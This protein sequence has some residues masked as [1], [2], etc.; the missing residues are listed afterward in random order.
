MILPQGRWRGRWQVL[1]LAFL[2]GA[3]AALALA[4]FNLWFVIFP[5]FAVVATLIVT[6]PSPR[7]AAWRAWSAGAGWFALSVHWIVQPF[8][9]DPLATGW[10]APF[11]LV[12]LA[13]G[14]ALFWGLAGW[15]SARIC[16]GPVRALA[17]AGL[18]TL[19]EALRGRV[20]TGLPWAEPGHGLIG[21]EALA[22]S[23]FIGPYGLTLVVLILSAGTAALFMAD[24]RRWS[25]VPVAIGLAL[26]LIPLAPPA[27]EPAADAPVVRVVQIN[28]PQHLKW[29]RDMIPVFFD[30]GLTL[31]AQAAGPLGAPDLIIWPETSLPTLLGRSEDARA[32]IAEA[33]G[34]AEL[35]IGGQR[36]AGDEP[37]NMLAHLGASGMVISVYDKHHLVPFGEYLPLRALA[38]RLG[39]RGVAQ[40]LSGGYRPGVGPALMD[41]GPF[42][43]VFPMICY[44]AIFPRYIHAVERPDWMVQVTNDAWFGSFSMPYQHLALARLRAAEQG[45]PLIRAANTGVSAVIDARGAVVQSLPMDSQGVLDARL[46]PAL[47]LT[48]YSRTGDIPAL[49][50]AIFVTGA[51]LVA[52]RRRSP[53]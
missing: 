1:A 29:R 30:R 49:L 22:L 11:A 42:G 39:L 19:T 7:K 44:E 24:Y 2:S 9:V 4:P 27:P 51:A 26:G 35:L 8:F 25:L 32:R 52:V 10:M 48:L 5:T 17:F 36:Y 43:Q 38:E 47:P 37:R 14:L 31:S 41:L 15:L 28:A 21:S 50:I 46:P 6:A 3:I 53:H 23:A 34:E 20:F 13:G 12:L 45:L 18:L 40:Q 16:S 33:A